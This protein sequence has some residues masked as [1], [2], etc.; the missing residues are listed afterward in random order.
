[1]TQ[2]TTSLPVEADLVVV[3]AGAAG[4]VLAARLSEDR[5]RS[6]I[7]LE[8]GTTTGEEP[9]SRTPGNAFQLL[10][11]PHA[12]SDV[13]TP[14]AALGGR[15]IGLPQG[16]GLGG[17]S[18]M[19]MMAWFHGRPED[20][21][22]WQAR[23]AAGWGWPEVRSTLRL[24]EDS[25][26]GA[27][28][29]HGAGGPMAITSIRDAG[30]LPL[31][32]VAAGVEHGLPLVED[33][34]GPIGEGV[35]LIQ[36]NIRDGRRHSVVDGY[37][38]PAR[39]RDNLTVA[40]GHQVTGVLWDGV[41]AVGVRVG[42]T[43]IRARS[44]VV[45]CAGALRSPQLL[46]LSGVGPADHLHD[47]GIPVVRDLPGVGANLQDH[48]MVTP[49]WPV[50]DGSPLWN[51]LTAD[52]VRDYRL[53]RRG[54]L[55]SLTQAAATLRSEAA[56]PVADLQFTLTLLGMTAEMTLIE[57]PVVTCAISVLD[58]DSHGTVRLAGVDPTLAPLVDPGY[59]Q[60]AGDRAR[61]RSGLRRARE[62]FRTPTLAKATGGEAL[63]PEDWSDEGLDT[64]IDGNVGSEW[65]PV[66]TCRMGTDTAAVIDPATMAV[67]GTDGLFV[68]DASV[69][70]TITRGNTQAPT[71][72]IAE[73][74]AE[75]IAR[76]RLR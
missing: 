19:N 2:L 62:L 75:R 1:M 47:L 17:G 36:S 45:L 32:F 35:G 43:E 16:R 38:A 15:R 6:V 68:A 55:A 58:P 42:D 26:R 23:G 33:F 12:W 54:P 76:A 3:G 71:I 10:A 14:Q 27:D 44:G 56:R 50:I 60:D 73:R 66:G 9:E 21:D 53:L 11:G 8:A 7:L 52:D 48:P 37:L 28:D 65:H 69:M 25:D 31:T 57:E 61:L 29:W 4:C 72:M 74:A 24:I 39:G 41:R 30:P 64:W 13:T 40:T 18:S 5:T 70:P 63:A 22:T 51:S 34:N 59:L 20:Y 46:L 49:V 67:H